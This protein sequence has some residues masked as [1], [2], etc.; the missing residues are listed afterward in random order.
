[1]DVRGCGK[2]NMYG[3]RAEQMRK[4]VLMSSKHVYYCAYAYDRPCRLQSGYYHSD[5]N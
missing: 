4:A 5:N 1:M 2:R 3:C